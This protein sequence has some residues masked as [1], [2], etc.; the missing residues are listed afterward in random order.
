MVRKIWIVIF[1][2]VVLS[3]AAQSQDVLPS[4]ISSSYDATLSGM[5][6][7]KSPQ[8]IHRMVEAMDSPDWVG[9]A[10]SGE[11]TSREQAEKQLLGLLA[12]PVSQRPIPGQKI[13]F[14]SESGSRALVVY[15]VYRTTAEGPV[16]SMVRDT[17]RQ[18]G[19]GWRRSMHEK[20]FPDRLLKLP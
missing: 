6:S 18:T 4:A 20:L 11:K 19:A 8:D 17:W 13:V 10:P 14:V 7:S 3:C 16:G 15:W 2:V 5:Q 1:S 12:I 9:V